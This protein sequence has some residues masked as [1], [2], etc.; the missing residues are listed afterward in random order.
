MKPKVEVV[1]ETSWNRALNAARRT[2]GKKPLDKEPSD[3]WKKMV[4]MAEHSPIKLV[5]Y[6][7]SFTD[8]RQWVGVHL[9]RHE[10]TIPMIHSQRVDRREDIDQLVEKVMTILSDDIKK[11]DDFNKRDYLFQGEVNDQDFYVNAQTLINISRK[12]LCA[13]ASP[14][15]RYAWKIVKDAI[16]DIDPIMAGFMVANCVYRGRCPEMKSCGYYLT[17]KHHKE[18]DEYWK[19]IER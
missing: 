19:Q 4:I 8:L 17:E 13:C 15:T 3:N 5:E 14:E 12:R 1:Q 11:S 16:A 10:H 2:I 7:I 18:V 9:L 6:R